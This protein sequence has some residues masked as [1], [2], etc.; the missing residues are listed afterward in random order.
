MPFAVARSIRN[1]PSFLQTCTTSSPTAVALSREKLSDVEKLPEQN[2]RSGDAAIKPGRPSPLALPT[3]RPTVYSDVE[4]IA[5]A[6]RNPQLVPVS[7][8]ARLL[9]KFSNDFL[10][11]GAQLP[12]VR[13]RSATQKPGPMSAV[14]VPA[15]RMQQPCAPPC[16]RRRLA[17]YAVTRARCTKFDALA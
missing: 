2:R 5:H 8:I 14:V 7:T 17:R 1:I 6:S 11:P 16:D 9:V 13:A 3:R 15:F 10:R 12:L 4:P